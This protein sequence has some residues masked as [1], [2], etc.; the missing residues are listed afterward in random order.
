MKWK[1]I[2]VLL[3]IFYNVGLI[4][5]C[6]LVMFAITH[7]DIGEGEALPYVVEM[8]IIIMWLL[9]NILSMIFSV[10]RLKFIAV[11]ANSIAA[12]ICVIYYIWHIFH[13]TFPK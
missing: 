3:F 5:F 13:P 2:I 6:G 8:S 10:R 4:I 9:I 12:I 1:A 7:A 11:S